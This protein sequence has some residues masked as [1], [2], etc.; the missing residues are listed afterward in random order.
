MNKRLIT[1]A[2]NT[3]GLPI[4]FEEKYYSK[5]K[6][7]ILT[8]LQKFNSSRKTRVVHKLVE[9]NLIYLTI[10][11]GVGANRLGHSVFTDTKLKAILMNVFL[12]NDSL[13]QHGSVKLAGEIT[14]LRH[15]IQKEKAYLDDKQV[16]NIEQLNIQ[17]D[18]AM[19]KLI[20]SLDYLKLIDGIYFEYLRFLSRTL[21]VYDLKA[22]P[23]VLGITVDVFTS[24]LRSIYSKIN[25]EIGHEEMR[26]LDAVSAFVI[27]VYYL[28]HDARSAFKKMEVGYDQDA[29]NKIKLTKV[30]KIEKLEDLAHLLQALELMAVTPR[31]L[32]NAFDKMFSS[33][34]M[35]NYV[36]LS[37]QDMLAFF[38]NLN[39]NTQLF[40][41]FPSNIDM[42]ARL[43]E[44]LLNT[45]KM[46]SIIPRSGPFR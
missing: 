33:Y 46:I 44:L 4:E 20:N 30:T 18:E 11:S 10:V 15:L 14:H 45:K 24:I 19:D 25:R 34:G 42:H 17:L 26:I 16:Y 32:K 40:N 35:D 8:T 39:Y 5:F 23:K 43:E 13:D 7:R 31:A 29:I 38:A 21:L 1:E 3:T 37:A 6:K 2:K 28:G 36:E 12:F 41:A 22:R 9:D 27:L